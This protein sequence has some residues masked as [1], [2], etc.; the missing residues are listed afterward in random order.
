MCAEVG[1]HHV[2]GLLANVL[3]P[4]L[5]VERR[6]LVAQDLDLIGLEQ[7]GKEEIPVAVK[8]LRLLPG[9]LHANA[10]SKW[11][12]AAANIPYSCRGG[13]DRHGKTPVAGSRVSMRVTM[14]EVGS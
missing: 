5:G 8:A 2:A 1:P 4:A 12:R 11:D 6:D 3:G 14:K 7:A 10:S 9:E 13:G